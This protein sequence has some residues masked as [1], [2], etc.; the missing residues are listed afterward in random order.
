MHF[1]NLCTGKEY[2]K[3]ETKQ[4]KIQANVIWKPSI[5]VERFSVSYNCCIIAR[6]QIT[7]TVVGHAVTAWTSENEM[8]FFFGET[9]KYDNKLLIS[10]IYYCLLT[11]LDEEHSVWTTHVFN[12][13]AKKEST[14]CTCICAT[15]KIMRIYGKFCQR[16]YPLLFCI[17]CILCYFLFSPNIL[18]QSVIHAF[19]TPC[20][21]NDSIGMQP[22]VT[23]LTGV[24]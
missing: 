15:A 9:E 10:C 5:I 2:P 17:D 22:T 4:T 18:L 16:V 24:V 23:L 7:V 21:L 8:I 20:I 13:H 6:S 14:T 1:D 12:E 11:M 19:R 3:D